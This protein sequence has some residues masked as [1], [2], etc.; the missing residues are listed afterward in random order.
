M[1]ILILNSI[2]YTSE[3]DLIPKV[4]TIK[5]TMIYGMCLGFVNLGHK[6]TLGAL[7]DYR[8]T[9]NEHYDFPIIFFK[10]D[11]KR[12]YK[13]SVLPYSSEMKSYLRTHCQDYD[14]VIS[15]E[16]FQFQSLY[17]A[18]ICPRKTIIWQ[19]LT[20]HQNKFHKIPSKIWHN[21]VARLCMKKV[22]A[23]VPRSQQAY[24]FIS[25]YMPS[26][27][28]IIVDHGINVDK[29]KATVNKKKQ[30]ISSSQLIYRKNVDGII[31]IF[32]K[33]HK[34]D[35]YQDI[36]LIIAGRGE[37]ENKLKDLA[38]RRGLKDAVDFVGFLSQTDLND[39]IRSSYCLLVNTRK[40]LNMVSIPESIVSGTPILT[41]RQPASADY[42]EKNGLGIVRD[43][44]DENDIVDIIKNNSIYVDNC[45]HYR[46]KLT[47]GYSAQLFI[48]IFNELK[49]EDSFIK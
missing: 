41:N 14:I 27:S 10:S 29:F 39:Y 42:I 35:G 24:N 19:E 25:K 5:D 11:L 26:V 2:L 1:N 7:E 28:S 49:N 20:E 38:N 17:A 16:V 4:K 22:L 34:I 44:W 6:I 46:N 8:P 23:V 32:E 30:I 40:D 3:S 48:N 13:P 21:V 9:E 43:N 45:L 12:I 33:F 15:S 31:R 37:E 36:K 47:N 18:S